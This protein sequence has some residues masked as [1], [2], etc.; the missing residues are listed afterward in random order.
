MLCIKSAEFGGSAIRPF[1]YEGVDGA[2]NPTSSRQ[3]A[4]TR[5]RGLL[6]QNRHKADIAG[7]SLDG[8][9]GMSAYDPRR[10]QSNSRPIASYYR[11]VCLGGVRTDG[12]RYEQSQIQ[13]RPDGKLHT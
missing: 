4:T 1:P 2:A 6:Q 13:S 11:S 8:M 9:G 5:R 7:L 10:P 3:P 12:E